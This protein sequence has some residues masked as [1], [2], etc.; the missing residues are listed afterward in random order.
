MKKLIVLL[1]VTVALTISRERVNPEVE[2]LKGKKIF[3]KGNNEAAEKIRSLIREDK[4]SCFTLAA[5]EADADATF[6]IND[7][8]AM[9]STGI[10]YP[11]RPGDRHPDTQKRRFGLVYNRSLLRCPVYERR[12]NRSETGLRK[13]ET[14][15]CLQVDNDIERRTVL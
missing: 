15:C 5:K 2:A 9:E 14:R 4:K 12:Q 3:V 8:S 10:H 7:Q 13:D 1:G 6:A 11:K